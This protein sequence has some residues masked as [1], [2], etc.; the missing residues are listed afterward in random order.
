MATLNILDWVSPPPMTGAPDDTS[1]ASFRLLESRPEFSRQVTKR[2]SRVQV[3]ADLG[4]RRIRDFAREACVSVGVSEAP[5]D[6]Q[7]Y[8]RPGLSPSEL[9]AEWEQNLCWTRRVAKRQTRSSIETEDLLQ[10]TYLYLLARNNCRPLFPGIRPLIFTV[11][12]HLTWQAQSRRALTAFFREVL[13]RS[14]RAQ[15]PN[16][17][18]GYCDGI[19]AV[20]RTLNEHDRRLIRFRFLEGRST[21]EIAEL[22]SARPGTV[23]S[24]LCRLMANLRTTTTRHLLAGSY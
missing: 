24:Q 16:E 22:T 1:P 21:H 2:D 4:R 13:F 12:R 14:P 7:R 9:L 19:F 11:L 3:Y 15:P 10:D 8:F 18:A 23:K 20:M 6:P 5:R 17:V